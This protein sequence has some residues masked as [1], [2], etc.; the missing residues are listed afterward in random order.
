M[1]RKEE[2]LQK[3]SE[4]VK[5]EIEMLL[6]AASFLSTSGSTVGQVA[7]NVY[8]ENFALHLRNLIEFY[9][10]D[11]KKKGL[12]RVADY[13]GKVAEWK[14]SR[15][16]KSAG[17]DRENQKANNFVAHLTYERDAQKWERSWDWGAILAELE[18]VREQFL[19]HLPKDRKAWF[20]GA[21]FEVPARPSGAPGQPLAKGWTGPPAP[22]EAAGASRPAG[23]AGATGPVGPI[24]SGDGT[25]GE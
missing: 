2:E 12:V 9:Y 6:A 7:K 21:K 22:N 16:P 23:G 11:G 19:S 13:V 4:H 3:A 18:H 14:E 1:G 8:I 17:L 5:Y 20:A 24:G 25:R 15:R 10:N